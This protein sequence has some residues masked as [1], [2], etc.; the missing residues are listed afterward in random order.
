MEVYH[1]GITIFSRQLTGEGAKLHGGRW[2]LIG[3]PC[4]YTSETK[5]LC[6]LEFASN[7]LRYEIPEDLSITT[8][9]LPD[10]SWTSFQ[11]SDL[12]PNW[13]ETPAPVSTK[14]WGTRHLQKHFALRLPSIIIPSEFNFILN[15]LHSE[16]KKLRIEKVEPFTFDKRIKT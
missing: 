8:Y 10:N 9:Y 15:P 4:L 5:A 2:N 1:I 7:V 16:F 6:V 11:E 14:E 3:Y 13:K 12:P